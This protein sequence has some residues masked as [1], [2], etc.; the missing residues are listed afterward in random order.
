VK[1][2]TCPV[3]GRVRR[4]GDAFC[5]GCGLPLSDE[6]ITA[7]ERLPVT[8]EERYRETGLLRYMAEMLQTC[9][10]QDEACVV[11]GHFVRQIFDGDSGSILVRAEDSSRLQP[12]CSWGVEPQPD[13]VPGRSC[14]VFAHGEP[15]FTPHD[16]RRAETVCACARTSP[17]DCFCAPLSSSTPAGRLVWGVLR[18]QPGLPLP[19][20][21]CMPKKWL[22]LTVAEQI[23]TALGSL[24]LERKLLDLTTHDPLTG[25]F[26]RRF[27]DA[28]LESATCDS[29]ATGR[30][31]S[32]VM[33]DIDHFRLFNDAHG[34][35]GGDALLRGL[36][37]CLWEA[38]RP[39][40]LACRYGGEEFTLLLPDT[41]LTDAQAVA[42]RVRM[43]VGGLTVEHN[44]RVLAHATI[45]LGVAQYPLHG[46]RG[47]SV[48]EAADR[49]LYQAKHDGRNRVAVAPAGPSPAA[50]DP[51]AATPV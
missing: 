45:S 18:V 51:P 20:D 15:F 23:Q 13:Q 14:P 5:P 2:E 43:E 3:C 1:R 16:E 29:N 30:P 46:A 38:L 24:E 32:V 44:G 50:P 17:G 39:R 36:G 31:L 33:I 11:I 27:L 35:E 41:T 49:A 42:E 12:P 7:A 37:A 47:E 6:A 21:R 25:L 4:P 40:D 22:V 10:T 19:P 28:S 48:L 34:H 8:E 26:N 9:R